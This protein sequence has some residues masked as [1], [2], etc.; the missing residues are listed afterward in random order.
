MVRHSPSE[1]PGP[2][3]WQG[4]WR[5]LGW[6]LAVAWLVGFAC[7]PVL[8]ARHTSYADL[9]AAL[10]SGQVT[11]VEVSGALEPGDGGWSIARVTWQD[12]RLT[13]ITEVLDTG[14]A[15]VRER[16]QSSGE[17]AVVML[18]DRIRQ[19]APEEVTI[20]RTSSAE[21]AAADFAGFRAPLA[22]GLVAIV[23]GLVTLGLL[24]NGPEPRR[25]NRWAFGWLML[26]S[27][28]GLIGY[29]ILGSPTGLLGPA[30]GRLE[31]MRGGWG[32]VFAVL[33]GAL[34]PWW[35]R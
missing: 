14:S 12:G 3:G 4:H 19:M 29:L 16:K 34:V 21:P 31:Q 22:L 17:Q 23:L 25:A 9:S 10:R 18:V 2:D 28:V 20:R 7:L 35:P 33:I 27:P 6:A 15:G 26:A 5:R 30:S 11:S 13:R 8:G 1:P 24:V 32:F